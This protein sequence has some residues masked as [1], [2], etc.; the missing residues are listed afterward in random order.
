[1][2]LTSNSK[3]SRWYKKQLLDRS[4]KELE[5][6]LKRE[7]YNFARA[8]SHFASHVASVLRHSKVAFA[9]SS[10]DGLVS[11]V[12]ASHTALTTMGFRDF[13][14]GFWKLGHSVWALE[15]D[16]S[17]IALR[18]LQDETVEASR[19]PKRKKASIPSNIMICGLPADVLSVQGS[20]FRVRF[21]G[22]N[23]V[24]LQPISKCSS[25]E[26]NSKIGAIEA[27]V[28]SL[29]VAGAF[30]RDAQ[31]HLRQELEADSTLDK[32]DVEEFLACAM[33]D[34]EASIA[35]RVAS[36]TAQSILH[37]SEFNGCKI[38]DFADTLHGRVM[39]NPQDDQLDL[40]IEGYPFTWELF[41]EGK[42]I[43][44]GAAATEEEACADCAQA[45]GVSIPESWVGITVLKIGPQGHGRVVEEIRDEFG[46]VKWLDVEYASGIAGRISLDAWS[47]DSDETGCLVENL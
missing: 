10:T 14:N 5:A 36:R 44:G 45:A 6:K 37:W 20:N 23:I 13:G 26:G 30:T 42:A 39:F 38:C 19:Y 7:G 4:D 31:D 17:D 3:T 8:N 33:A 15:S 11:S 1:M 34:K 22:S 12:C 25:R 28:K 29:I 21:L 32:E 27:Q 9:S 35:H 40:D 18:R 41:S 47:F 43:E 16:G 2:A 24:D 46:N